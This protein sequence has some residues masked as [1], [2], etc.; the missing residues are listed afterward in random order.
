M[1]RRDGEL[2][3]TQFAFLS[4]AASHRH[5]TIRGATRAGRAVEILRLKY[6]EAH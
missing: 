5:H 2:F 1:H 4:R 3:G 6:D